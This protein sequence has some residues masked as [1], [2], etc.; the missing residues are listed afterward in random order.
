MAA[1]LFSIPLG[2]VTSIVQN[3]AYALPSQRVLVFADG[4]PT[5]TVSNTEAFTASITP[6]ITDGCFQTAAAFIKC[7]SGTINIIVKA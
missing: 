7:T 6:T 3:V 2:V 5:I 1:E 4:T